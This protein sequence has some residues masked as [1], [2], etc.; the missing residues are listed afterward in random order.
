[1][2]HQPYWSRP[3]AKTLDSGLALGD[4]TKGEVAVMFTATE[5]VIQPLTYTY[6]LEMT[7]LPPKPLPSTEDPVVS[8]EASGYIIVQPNRILVEA[9]P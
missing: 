7:Y 3:A 8:I 4:A 1:M 6:Q 2:A 9:T 5:M